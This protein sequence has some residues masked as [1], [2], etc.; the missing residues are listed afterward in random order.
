M[1]P[2]RFLVIAP[3]ALD[4]VLGCGG[5]MRRAAR[6]GAEVRTLVLTGGDSERHQ[7]LKAAALAA[8][9]V[10]ATKPPT[11]LDLPENRTDTLGL[12]ELI[13]PIERAVGDFKPDRVVVSHGGNL[14]IDHQRAFAATATACRPLPGSPVVDLLAY[15]VRSSTDWAPNGVY[16]SFEPDVFVDISA[17]LEAKMEALE[18]YE[19]EM[20]P[21]PHAR[22]L[23]AMRAL[24]ALRGGTVGVAAAEAFALMRRVERI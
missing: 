6:G 4:E 24:A 18:L 10:L 17:D 13:A 8:A 2:E 16:A 3:H 15:E 11:F 7:R 5:T 23:T 14:N 9:Q 1:I 21:E 22:S 19:F 20:R 12:S